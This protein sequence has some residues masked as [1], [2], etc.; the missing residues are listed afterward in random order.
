MNGITKMELSIIKLIKQLRQSLRHKPM[1]M[2]E[3]KIVKKK[4][5]IVKKPRAVF[6]DT[7]VSINNTKLTLKQISEQYGLNIKT[8][9]ARYKVGNRGRL[10]CRPT[11]AKQKAT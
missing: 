3:E 7:V 1:P 5:V 10:L 9:E 6:S 2:L 11:P 4:E 8:V